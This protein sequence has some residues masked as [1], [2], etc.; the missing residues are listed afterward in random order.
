MQMKTNMMC[1]H[2]YYRQQQRP[3]TTGSDKYA[4]CACGRLFI[5]GFSAFRGQCSH[6]SDALDREFEEQ[7]RREK[8][9][10]KFAID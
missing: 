10:D 1:E 9:G 2:D 8:D 7:E 6:C 4:R 3:S 5:K